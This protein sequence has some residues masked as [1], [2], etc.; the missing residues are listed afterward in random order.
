[1]KKIIVV[2][3]YNEEKTVAAV[4]SAIREAAPDFDILVINDGSTDRTSEIV[5]SFP[6]VAVIDLPINLG[7]GGAVQTGFLYAERNGYDLAVQVDADGQHKPGE[8][9]K[10]LEP[11]LSG[12][13]DVAVGSRFIGKSGYK[14]KTSR[15]LGIK[16]FSLTNRLLLRE[17]I[18]DS[19]SGF[20]SYNRKAIEV[21]SGDYPDDYPEPEALY[22]LKKKGLRIREVGVDMAGRLAGRSSISFFRSIYYMFKVFLAIFVLMLRKQE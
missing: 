17:R 11:V 18:T 7:I 4:L 16:I 1:M 9:G 3:A 6:S 22:I 21:L 20:R 8:I 15:Q 2:P 14:G 19:T 10:I 5:R 12:E 13:A